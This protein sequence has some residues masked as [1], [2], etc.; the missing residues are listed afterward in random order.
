MITLAEQI[1]EAERELALRRT[2]SPQWMQSGNS[3]WMMPPTRC[4]VPVA[5]P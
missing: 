4:C 1:A 3:P 5:A 2:C